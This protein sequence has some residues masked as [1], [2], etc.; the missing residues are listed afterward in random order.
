MGQN[1][2]MAVPSANQC[3]KRLGKIE[4]RLPEASRRPGGEHDRHIAF[5]VRKKT[6]AYFTDDHH[7]DGRLSL[8][9]RA[10]AGEQAALVASQ[11]ES[12]FIPA[13]LGH[14]GWVGMWL[15][16]PGLDW[17]EAEELMIEAYRL[18]APKRLAASLE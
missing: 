4:S 9:C 10:P 11:P 5:V 15:D 8:I 16:V 14:R 13:Y 12:F 6:F 18:A 17:T 1:Q 7:G 2:S 3:K